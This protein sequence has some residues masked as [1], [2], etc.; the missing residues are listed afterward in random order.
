M[1]IPDY[2]TIM[3]PL[4]QFAGDAAEQRFRDAVAAL[5]GHFNLTEEERQELLPSGQQP[6]FNNRVAWARLY[7][8]K[9]GLLKSTRRG[10]FQITDQGQKAL[11]QKPEKIDKDFLMQFPA[12]VEVVKQIKREN[13]GRY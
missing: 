7:L 13:P 6:L 11:A 12:F 1:A 9:A 2:Q 10:Y 5:A 8:V 3:L 4:L